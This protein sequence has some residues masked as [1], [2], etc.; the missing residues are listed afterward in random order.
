MLQESWPRAAGR[1]VSRTGRQSPNG[2][3]SEDLA[4]LCRVLLQSDLVQDSVQEVMS[5]LETR[6]LVA[7]PAHLERQ[8]AVRVV[9]S[10]HYQVTTAY[11]ETRGLRG[12]LRSYNCHEWWIEAKH[13]RGWHTSKARRFIGV[14]DLEDFPV[15]HVVSYARS[16]LLFDCGSRVT[17][18]SRIVRIGDLCELPFTVIE[19]K[20]SVPDGLVLPRATAGFSKIRWLQGRWVV[21]DEHPDHV[22]ATR[23]TVCTRAGTEDEDCPVLP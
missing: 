11:L 10:E 15:Q 1:M 16:A 3:A 2:D 19:C 14:I 20:N 22:D 4:Q 5:R 21:P 23:N 8:L 6:H 12:R 18:D 9:S 17:I 7:T 13:R